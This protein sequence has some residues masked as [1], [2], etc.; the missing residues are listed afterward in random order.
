MRGAEAQASRLIAGFVA[1]A[2]CAS[3]AWDAS[4]Q[5]P[6]PSIDAW[7]RAERTNENL[8]NGF[9]DYDRAKFGNRIAPRRQPA[10]Q[11]APTQPQN[12]Y[13]QSPAQTYAPEQAQAPA[14]QPPKWMPPAEG[15]PPGQGMPETQYQT[16]TRQV[17][18]D[19]L[20][21]IDRE[22]GNDGT[23]E[24]SRFYLTGHVGWP[25]FGTANFDST[26]SENT[27]DLS[28]LAVRVGGGAGYWF[29]KSI[30]GELEGTYQI[31]EFDGSSDATVSVWSLI[32]QIR[33]EM[34]DTSALKPYISGGLGL[35]LFRAEDVVP[36]G[37]TSTATDSGFALAYQLG[38]GLAYQFSQKNAVDF[39]YRYFGTTD[40]DLKLLG[41]EYASNTT[42]HTLMVGIRHQF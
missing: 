21:R 1:I 15:T 7:L 22:Y 42:N 20:E 29:G 34:S 27:V 38:A 41:T 33:F 3:V 5:Q 35:A 14:G 36:I 13:Q 40:A 9:D 2:A 23:Q 28:L 18:P 24:I 26:S 39:G 37:N 32:P 16:N 25:V 19:A 8:Q 17:P 11:Y 30:S 6:P 10:Q 12:Y 4:A 31:A